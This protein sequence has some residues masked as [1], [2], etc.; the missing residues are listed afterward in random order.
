MADRTNRQTILL[1]V[2]AVASWFKEPSLCQTI[3]PEEPG[4]SPAL[5]NYSN[6]EDS[7]GRGAVALATVNS[8][9]TVTFNFPYEGTQH[10]KLKLQKGGG[11]AP[12]VCL[13]LE[14]ANFVS[15]APIHARFDDG[16]PQRFNG[17]QTSDYKA[18]RVGVVGD[19][20]NRFIKQLRVAKKVQI[21]A[22]FF[23]EGKRVFEFDI[24]GL[25]K[26]W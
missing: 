18:D 19:D 1:L 12:S 23:Q 3:R 14:H 16:K 11:N 24:R 17:V 5:W 8:L 7:M 26:N 20:Y 4:A 10:A 9:N 6:I 15:S 22:T 25:D 2:F 13:Q 21:E